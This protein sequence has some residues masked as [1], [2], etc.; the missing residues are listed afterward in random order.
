[1]LHRRIYLPNSVRRV[2]CRG[3][4]GLLPETQRNDKETILFICH[5]WCLFF[6]L[7]HQPQIKMQHLSPFLFLFSL[8]DW[9]AK[10]LFPARC[11]DS[12]CGKTHLRGDK[13]EF[14]ICRNGIRADRRSLFFWM[15]V[16]VGGLRVERGGGMICS[17]HPATGLLSLMERFDNVRAPSRLL[18]EVLLAN[19]SIV[20]CM[21]DAKKNTRRAHKCTGKL[22]VSARHRL[23]VVLPFPLCPFFCVFGFLCCVYLD[24]SIQSSGN[25]RLILIWLQ[26]ESLGES[27]GS[28]NRWQK[29]HDR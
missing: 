15:Y 9:S 21:I 12:K 8:Q 6:L 26:Y 5:H 11:L 18:F 25:L 23:H 3:G 27:T 10:L 13:M 22:I 19:L 28:K 14:R 4:E 29:K 1:M 16:G 7:L 24:L 17:R 2:E 20:H